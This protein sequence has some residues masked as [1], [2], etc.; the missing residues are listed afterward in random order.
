MSVK[1]AL[2]GS[3]PARLAF[4]GLLPEAFAA[5]SVRAVVHLLRM[6]SEP[7]PVIMLKASISDAN[8]HELAEA[9]RMYGKKAQLQALEIPFNREMG[10]AGLT[11]LV[12][13]LASSEIVLE[14][15]DLSYNP[16]LGSSAITCTQPLWTK[17]LSILRLVDCGLRPESLKIL[18]KAASRHWKMIGDQGRCPLNRCFFF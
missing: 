6:K 7:T 15:M 2:D 17:S 14:E 8:A 3:L 5:I 10:H 9:F 4:W 13:G 11:E 18:A 12:A 1:F 16:Q